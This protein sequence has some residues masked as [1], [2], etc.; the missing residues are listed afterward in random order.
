MHTP[1]QRVPPLWL[2]V[3]ITLAGTVA[4]HMFVPALPDAAEHLQASPGQAQLT[5]TVYII[6]L[7]VG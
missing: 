7:G 6:G 4:M 3:L 2:L 5:I 1:P